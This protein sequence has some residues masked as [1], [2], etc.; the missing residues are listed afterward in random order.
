LARAGW[1]T[2]IVEGVAEKPVY[3]SIVDDKVEVKDASR[4]W[5][6]DAVET[7]EALKRELRLSGT[8]FATI[9]PA[10]EKQVIF[11]CIMYDLH[12][13][14][15]RAGLGAVMGSKNLKAVAVRA[16]SGKQAHDQAKLSQIARWL[17]DEGKDR[18]QDLQA[19]GT[20]GDV[21]G[22]QKGGGLPTRNFQSGQF[23]E[24]EKIAGTTMTK[25]ILVERGTCSECVVQC[26][27]VVEVKDGP[28]P[29]D[30]AY[31]GPE[32]ETVGAFGSNCG[33]GDMAAVSRANQICNGAG[34]DTIGGGMMV[35]FAMECFENGLITEK[36]TGGLKLNFGNAEAMV[37]LTEMIANREGI[38]DL[39]AQGYQACIDA[40]G[41]KAEK[42][43]L[44]VK[45]Q[46][47]PLHEPRYKFGLGVG[48][49]ISPTGADHTHNVHD[50]AFTT[51]VGLEPLNQFGILEPL[52]ATDLSLGKVRLVYYHTL[53]RV[54]KNTI[55]LC[56]FL[57]Y[58]PNTIVE[59]VRAVTGWNTSLFELMKVAERNMAMARAFNAREGF[60][61]SDDTLPDRFFEPFTSGPLKGVAQD[62][63]QFQAALTAYYQMAG[64]DS[65]TAAPTRGKYG[66]LALD[67]VADD[68]VGN[69]VAVS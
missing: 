11:A 3:I 8:R 57:P 49:A 38:G 26:K 63:E 14:A 59:I 48:Y 67:W 1:D 20:A 10:G 19:H 9:G 60:T 15:G 45:Q 16:S 28:F 58:S 7:E 34:L 31:G 18:Y 35:S 29:V 12:H 32:Y 61:A 4:L 69:G 23:E 56:L 2:L 22:L 33:V 46:P 37:K 50:T 40:W 27:R 13:A 47:L 41:P 39:L 42:Y 62:R 24:A 55:G 54:L 36:D 51:D 44:H 65:V 5:G 17:L 6:K 52:K 64:W 66:E 43:A 21:G 53:T 25:T 30:P 68:L